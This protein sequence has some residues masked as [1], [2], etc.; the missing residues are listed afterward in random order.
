MSDRK[1][2][3]GS[4]PASTPNHLAHVADDYVAALNKVESE[5][6]Q[7][8]D[9]TLTTLAAGAFALSI[10]FIKEIA[11]KPVAREWLLTAWVT[12]ACSLVIILFG[13]LVAG[14]AVGRQAGLWLE[15]TD[16][17]A[18]NRSRRRWNRV[19]HWLNAAAFALFVVG[20][21]ALTYF[22]N[23]NF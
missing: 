15:G 7:S 1:S 16:W 18:A 4:D 19:I 2:I 13:F 6:A 22:A 5:L 12:F 14:L 20:M 21:L 23:A 10:T 9:K 3:E 17:G 8:F 11:P